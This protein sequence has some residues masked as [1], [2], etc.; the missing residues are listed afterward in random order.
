ML[1][2]LISAALAEPTRCIATWNGPA[3]SGCGLP[4]TYKVEATASSESAAR[5][6]AIAQLGKVLVL[7]ADARR[8]ARPALGTSEFLRCEASAKQAFVDCFAEPALT[9]TSLCF[10]TLDSAQCWSNTPITLEVR[11]VKALAVGRERMCEAVDARIVAQAYTDTETRRAK[12]RAE[13]EAKTAV[14][15]PTT[16]SSMLPAPAAPSQ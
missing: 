1:T 9:E 11:G 6:A 4:D 3:P 13:C 10:A 2:L 15:C 7:D 8:I 12:C 14:R 5:K 16:P